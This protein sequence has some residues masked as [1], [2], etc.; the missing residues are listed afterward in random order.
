MKLNGFSE[1]QRKAVCHVMQKAIED[2]ACN[3]LALFEENEDVQLTINRDGA[4]I[5]LNEASDGLGGELFGET[6]WI[7]KYSNRKL[8]GRAFRLAGDSQKKG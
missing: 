3:M 1:E 4:V 5:N 7:S 2:A 6:G 8:A